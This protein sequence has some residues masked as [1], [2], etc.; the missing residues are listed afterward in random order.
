MPSAIEVQG[1]SRSFRTT[2]REPGLRAAV[3]AIARPRRLPVRA[4]HEVSFA[5][6]PGER[7]AFVGPNGAGKST[8][9]KMLSG[10]LHPSAGSASVLGLVP[11]RDRR[12]LGYQIGTVFGQRSRLWLHLPAADAFGL[13]ARVYDLDDRVFKRRRDELCE[14]FEVQELARKPVRVLSLG[15]RMRCELVACLLHSPRV[16]FLDEP[17]IGLDV[18]AK[19]K[20]RQL[21]LEQSRAEGI[22]ILLTSHD[23]GDM[24]QVCDRVLVING[25]ELLLDRPVADLR[26][27]YLSKKIVTVLSEHESLTI[28]LPGTA[29]VSAVPYRTVIEVDTRTTSIDAVVQAVLKEGA[30]QDLT[31]EDPPMDEIVQAIYREAPAD[32]AAAGGVRAS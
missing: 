27:T 32:R 18:V 10:I 2:V 12:R 6:E 9:I 11:W 21:I 28:A 7:V 5:I 4:V 14:L 15:E 30:L 23:T 31:V 25:G 17:T 3:R 1:L 24:E 22:T 20:L 19:A 16:L 8:T 13:L 29:V 26:R